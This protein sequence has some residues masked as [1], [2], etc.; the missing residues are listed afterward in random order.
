MDRPRKKLHDPL[1]VSNSSRRDGF[2]GQHFVVVPRPACEAAKIHPLLKGLF[3]TDAGYFPQAKGHYV[4]RERGA[5]THLVFACLRGR[6]WVRGSSTEHRVGAGDPSPGIARRLAHTA[7]AQECA[8]A[9]VV[10]GRSG[11]P[12]AR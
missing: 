8:R 2:V 1:M 9:G 7:H 4:A 3:V 10:T 11:R 12:A 5:G 6:G